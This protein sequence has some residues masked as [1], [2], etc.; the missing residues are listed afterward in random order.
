MFGQIFADSHTKRLALG[1]RD[2][3][4]EFVDGLNRLVCRKFLFP[5]DLERL[6]S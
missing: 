6:F 5:S 4:K 1:R 3:F 2:A